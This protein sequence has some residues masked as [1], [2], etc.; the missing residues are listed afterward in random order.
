MWPLIE[1]AVEPEA[2]ADRPRLDAALAQVAAADAAVSV[3]TDRESGLALLCASDEPSLTRALDRLV[4]DHGLA[5]RVGEPL[6]AYRETITR[7]VDVRA[8]FQ[9]ARVRLRFEPG[10]PRS[11]LV[12]VA[13][14]PAVLA[15]W[16]SAVA[17]GVEGA[18]AVGILAGFPAI[19]IRATL[20]DGAF[21]G[22]LPEGISPGS[23]SVVTAFTMAAVQAFRHL[24]DEGAPVLMEPVMRLD[25][26]V[27]EAAATAV[28]DDLAG[29]R[30]RMSTRARGGG[31][32]VVTAL[33]P[34]VE[35]FGYDDRL[36]RLTAGMGEG[37]M[38]FDHYA[39]LPQPAPDG[40][41]PPAVGL[42][43]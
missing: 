41:F 12:F 31:R 33:V 32:A 10:P 35:L 24:R 39:P 9:G 36:R 22:V 14:A 11:G 23:A 42:R 7:A 17:A 25:L 4:T 16:A 13:Q 15:D 8:R 20:V 21:S 34:L 37:S 29:H 28:L 38:A 18:T 30:G 5:L 2:A 19:D 26:D 43:A 3:A 1:I 6:V 40:A 27:P